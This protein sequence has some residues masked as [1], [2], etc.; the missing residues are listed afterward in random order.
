MWPFFKWK[1]GAFNF[2]A[3]SIGAIIPDL[4]CPFLFPFV[5][6]RWHARLF[7]HSLLGAF[8]L[9]L[10]LAAALTLW[11]VPPLLKWLEPRIANKRLFVFTGVDLRAHRTTTAALAGSAMLGS[12]S[13]VLIDVLH[14]PYNPLTFPFPQYYDFNLVLFG[15]L[16]LSGI[17]MQGTTLALLTLMLYFWWWRPATGKA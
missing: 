5:E 6:D 11:L 7:M 10:L 14:H 17:V 13:H 8:T 12:V 1:P 4:E 3:L 15:D 2:F 16:T 9:D